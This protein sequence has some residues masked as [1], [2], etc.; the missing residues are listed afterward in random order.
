MES[1]SYLLVGSDKAENTF[2]ST[3]H[4]SGRVLSRNQARKQFRGNILQKQ[5]EEKGIFIQT[6][7]FPGLAEEAGAAYKNIDEVVI[8][9]EQSG[10]SKPVVKLVPLGNVKG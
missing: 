7:S 4:G 9:T 3:V 1:G 2:Y 5:L 10:L 6:A 8:A